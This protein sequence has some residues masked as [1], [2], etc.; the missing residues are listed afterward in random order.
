ML[1]LEE[2]GVSLCI[3][4]MLDPE[5][6][7][8]HPA[9]QQLRAPITYLPTA[10][11]GA[12]KQYVRA[13]LR[14]LRRDPRCYAQALRQACGRA[15]M[16]AGLRHFL[17]AGWLALELER[18]DIHHLHAHFAHGP[19]ATA[20]FVHL[21]TGRSYSFTAHAKDIYTTPPARIAARIRQAR[22]VVTC[23]SHNATY[24]ASLVDT[25]TA[26]RIHQI[27]HG[28]DLRLF[29]AS[30]PAGQPV[31]VI[32]AVG[33]LVEKKGLHYLVAACALL[34]ERGISYCCRIAGGGPLKDQLREQITRL[35]LGNAIE[36]FGTCTQ[37]ELQEIYRASS[38]VALPCIIVENGDR[39][40]IPNV[41]VEAMGMSL[42]AVSTTVS[43]IPELI[44]DDVNGLLVPPRD[45]VALADALAR[46]IG[47]AALRQ[48]LGE[49]AARTV[50]HRFDLRHNVQRLEA[51]FALA[52]T[53][54]EAVTITE[55]GARKRV[56]P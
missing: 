37:D 32:L 27:Y 22:F 33:R 56:H 36:L 17:R 55:M 8:M 52:L 38:L 21:L 35:G 5:E 29:H 20:E 53:S 48:R 30:P 10:T 2:R 43:G 26:L 3:Y 15:D 19:A 18:E 41:L 11:K 14:L 7:V 42:P 46:L 16:W 51:L 49:E 54:D 9:V 6:G 31:P 34:R 13:H 23:T 24:L 25:P 47:D 50:T 39:D 1:A 4:A 12:L 44:E 28:V 45:A 40:G